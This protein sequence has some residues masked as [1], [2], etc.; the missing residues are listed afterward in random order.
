MKT[1]APSIVVAALVATMF[2]TPVGLAADRVIEIRNFIFVPLEVDARAGES[3]TWI[4]HDIVPH[5]ATAI[6]SGW[7]TGLI[8]PGEQKTLHLPESF[9]RDYLCTYHPAMRGRL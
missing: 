7:D 3:V 5:T 2:F 1:N 6:D 9:T 4:N 8:A